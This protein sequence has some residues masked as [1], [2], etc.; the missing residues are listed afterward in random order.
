MYIT[1]NDFEH[2]KQVTI[3][4]GKAIMDIYHK[5]ERGIEY[6]K[7]DS[8]LTQADIASNQIINEGLAELETAYPI[9]SEE[10]DQ[11]NDEDRAALETSWLID[12][13]DGTKEFISKNGEF[14]VCVA[15]IH[16]HKPVIGLV[17]AP[18]KDELYYAREGKGAFLQIDGKV[19]ALK[20]TAI[21]LQ[22]KNLRIAVSRSHMNPLNNSYIE[23]LEDPVFVPKGS[24]LKMTDIAVGN[25]DVYPRFDMK[26]KEWDIA[27]GQII[28]E[29]AGGVVID[30]STNEAVRYNKLSLQSPP[31]IAR[32]Q[33]I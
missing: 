16:Q 7:D 21:N 24:I 26:T 27:A 14:A 22:S 25:I 2:L 13:L 20:T 1:E 9:V 15:L 29:E 28:L 17:Y 6:K 4:A 12:P 11:W 23:K 33:S 10:N 19:Q 8:P 32:A 5:T 3:N 31:F 30:S 18:V